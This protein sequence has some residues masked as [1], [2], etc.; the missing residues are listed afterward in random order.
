MATQQQHDISAQ[1]LPSGVMATQQLPDIPAHL[2]IILIRY[3]FCIYHIA[4]KFRWVL[5]FAGVGAT[6]CPS[7][8][9]V[10]VTGCPSPCDVGV[11]GCPS[12]CDVGVTGCPSPC[13]VGVTGCP[14]P[15]DVAQ[16]GVL[17]HVMWA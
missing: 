7:P 9:D 15:C 17:A 5:T 11:T 14:S 8:C 10:G 16:Q 3:I 1:P 6:G 12:P 2:L 4:G 13:D